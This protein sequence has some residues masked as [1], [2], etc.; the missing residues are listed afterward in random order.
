[1]IVPFHKP[2]VKEPECSLCKRK[3][4]E[5]KSLISNNQ[6]GVARRYICGDCIRHAKARAT[7]S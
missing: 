3:D 2:P 7:E 5:V 6:E 1:M 4:S